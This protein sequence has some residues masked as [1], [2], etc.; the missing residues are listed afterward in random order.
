MGLNYWFNWSERHAEVTYSCNRFMTQMDIKL[1]ARRALI[2]PLREVCSVTEA[3]STRTRIFLNSQLF[4]SGYGFRPHAS[5]EFGSESGYFW[6]RYPEW[7]KL[8]RNESHK[9][10]TV[11]P[12]I[13]E[14]DDVA[15]SCPVSYRTMNQYGG[16][17]CRPSFS[18]VN[19]D[20]IGC[21]WTGEF[22]LNTLPLAEKFLNPERK[23]CGF[24]NIRIRVDR[25][26]INF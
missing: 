26:W 11:N 3:L 8:I 16:T 19:P 1:F 5:G 15:K 12:N 13:F 9:V 20:T 23:T 22:D 17:T 14:S 4:L 24:T 25:A 7:K 2:T 10:W 6:I 18:R 21:M